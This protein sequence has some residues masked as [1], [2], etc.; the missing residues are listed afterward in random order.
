MEKVPSGK[1]CEIKQ[2]LIEAVSKRFSIKND[3]SADISFEVEEVLD[4]SRPKLTINIK[5]VFSRWSNPF[6][7]YNWSKFWM[8][9][10]MR[11]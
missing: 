5:R 2:K 7:S 9:I 3:S 6:V 1:V 11:R 10:T 8:K 4:G